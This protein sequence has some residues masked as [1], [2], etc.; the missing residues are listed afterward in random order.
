M[1]LIK[2]LTFTLEKNKTTRNP[3]YRSNSDPHRHV[4]CWDARLCTVLWLVGTVGY[5]LL[6]HFSFV[7]LRQNLKI[8]SL[9]FSIDSKFSH[10]AFPNEN[11]RNSLHRDSCSMYPMMQQS[12]SERVSNHD[13]A[14]GHVVFSSHSGTQI[15]LCP[16]RLQDGFH[17][18]LS[19]RV[20]SHPVGSGQLTQ[21]LCVWHACMWP[22]SSS[23]FGRRRHC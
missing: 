17:S 8:G 2:P 6:S 23:S 14:V 13:E 21:I 22:A 1:W 20:V 18:R 12:V 11:W 19:V 9:P 4:G 15:T 3:T 16:V 7:M 10:V 5:A